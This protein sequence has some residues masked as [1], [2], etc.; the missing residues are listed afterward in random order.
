MDSFPHI[1]L[2]DFS[3]VVVDA[4]ERKLRYTKRITAIRSLTENLQQW[5][6]SVFTP[7][8]INSTGIFP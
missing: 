3:D 1:G 7:E 2:P 4:I 5:S 8:Y 6:N